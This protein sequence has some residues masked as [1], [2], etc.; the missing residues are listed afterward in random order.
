MVTDAEMSHNLLF[1]KLRSKNGNIIH[2]ESNSSGILRQ[3]KEISWNKSS[4]WSERQKARISN[5]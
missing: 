1:T 4:C 2:S 3:G 5:D